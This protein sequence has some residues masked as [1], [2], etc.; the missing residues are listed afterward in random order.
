M[1][2]PDESTEIPPVTFGIIATA[3]SRK[4]D[5]YHEWLRRDDDDDGR[6]T[7]TRKSPRS[8]I[9]KICNHLVWNPLMTMSAKK[10]LCTE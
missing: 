6:A 4:L 9:T 3:L 1:I 8:S 5:K 10:A 2:K 7:D